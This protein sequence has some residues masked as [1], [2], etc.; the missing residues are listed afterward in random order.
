M[1]RAKATLENKIQ[2][3]RYEHAIAREQEPKKG[4]LFCTFNIAGAGYARADSK[5]NPA[6]LQRIRQK[7]EYKPEQDTED[8]KGNGKPEDGKTAIS[9]LK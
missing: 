7:H 6:G 9:I 8:K 4:G 2:K 3:K 1:S 5:R